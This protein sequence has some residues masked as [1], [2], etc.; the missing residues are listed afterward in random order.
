MDCQDVSSSKHIKQPAL[1]HMKKFT[2]D[3]ITS[4]PWAL[5]AKP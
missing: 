1:A 3:K 4:A 2:G 5:S